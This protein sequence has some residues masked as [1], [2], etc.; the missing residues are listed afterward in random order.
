MQLPKKVTGAWL[1]HHTKKLDLIN[2][3][4]EYNSV[5]LA[6][7]AGILLSILSEN[8]QST[9]SNKQVQDLARAA[10]VDTAFELP[11]LLDKLTEQHLVSQ[12]QAGIEVLGLTSAA[13]LQ[14]ASDIF[15]QTAPSNVEQATLTLAEKCSEQPQP[16]T[17]LREIVSDM[18]EL[19]AEE[20][21]ALL[22]DATQIGFS[23]AE[24][25][26]TETIYFNG[27]IFRREE[28][29]KVRKVLSS[30]KGREQQMV[31]EADALLSAKGCM[32]HT[33]VE[34]VLG[35]P[36]FEKLL[37]VGMYELNEVSNT[38]ERAVY[39]TKP[40]AFCK[41]GNEPTADAFD[42]AKALVASL[43]YGMQRSPSYRGR[44]IMIE[45]LLNRLIG[46]FWV[47]PADAIGEDYRI[48]ELKKVV[49]VKSS[50]NGFSMK[51]LKKEIGQIA[52]AAIT[53]GDASEHSL[54][55]QGAAVTNYRGPE[56]KRT[57]VRQRKTL[58]IK[59]A[60]IFDILQSLRTG[61]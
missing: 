20:A 36:L 21:D 35:K 32:I 2:R 27:S 25:V 12:G 14:H 58:G 44:I 52:L 28:V 18:H 37:S 26:G 61:R 7:K 45:R 39:V 50:Y 48:L 43:S 13:V 9:L 53:Q 6:G 8:Q 42:L 3:P 46:G 40:S 31:R 41:F 59:A 34:A 19:S 11:V 30:L 51:L 33:E 24:S 60:D 55:L 1:V 56:E 47:G 54:D 38:R 29:E 5:R 10:G 17:L 23:D 22:E 57:E 49:H 4:G 16:S 15:A